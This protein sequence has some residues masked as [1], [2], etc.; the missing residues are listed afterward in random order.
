MN[1]FYLNR[2]DYAIAGGQLVTSIQGSVVRSD[3]A[4]RGHGLVVRR[5]RERGGRMSEEAAIAKF[6]YINAPP[7]IATILNDHFN[8]YNLKH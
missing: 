8:N 5:R 1:A 3:G 2:R 4:L 7:N 6:L